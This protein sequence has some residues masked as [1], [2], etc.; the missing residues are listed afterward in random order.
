[1]NGTKFKWCS[2][3]QIDLSGAHDFSFKSVVEGLASDDE[4]TFGRFQERANAGTSQTKQNLKGRHEE[5]ETQY[6]SLSAHMSD[7][8]K[9]FDASLFYLRA[10]EQERLKF[11]KN[12]KWWA[13]FWSWAAHEICDYG[14]SLRKILVCLAAA[15]L[16]ASVAAFF[17]LEPKNVPV[18][19]N[20]WERIALAVVDGFRILSSGQPA[21]FL[22]EAWYQHL[23]VA[24]MNFVGIA[25]VGLFGFVLGHKI[26][27]R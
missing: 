27:N 7:K 12:G 14:E 16:A 18:G 1:M 5:S 10:M 23:L 6:R 17:I 8:A 19:S 24:I 25:L 21:A 26:H 22:P 13:L 20:E 4:E 3:N 15:I 2:L 9:F 11:K